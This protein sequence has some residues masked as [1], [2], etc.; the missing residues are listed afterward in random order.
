MKR[1]LSIFLLVIMCLA[2]CKANSSTENTTTAQNNTSSDDAETKDTAAYVVEGVSIVPG[3]DF[4]DANAAL[5]EPAQYVEAASCYFDGMDK[6]FTYNGFEITTYPVGDKDYVQ[7]ICMSSDEYKTEEGITI[8]STLDEVIQAYG[9]DYEL[10]G[11]MYR[12]FYTDNTYMYFF[13]M[14]DGVKYFGYAINPEN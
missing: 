9:D 1:Y 11:K 3:K 12:Y 10:T 4:A 14:D 8:G 6:V 2:G 5:G 7:D 13:I